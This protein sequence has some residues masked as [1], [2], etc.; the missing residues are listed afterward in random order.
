[1]MYSGR[2][3]EKYSKESIVQNT[4]IEQ[5]LPLS[6]IDNFLTFEDML[7]T[8]QE[9]FM[10]VDTKEVYRNSHYSAD[11]DNSLYSAYV[12]TL[13]AKHRSSRRKTIYML[14]LFRY[15]API[16]RERRRFTD[17]MDEEIDDERRAR[18]NRYGSADTFTLRRLKNELG[19]RLDSY[20]EAE[21]MIESKKEG[22]PPFFREKPQICPIEEGK[23]AHLTCLAVGNPKP[24]IQWF[25]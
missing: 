9:A 17:V 10:Q 16:I 6:F 15:Q 3:A 20:A 25:K 18:I 23:P 5:Y 12:L 7:K 13:V 24:L 21:A 4:K 22:Q 19:T 2:E 11:A 8:D 1:M 14:L